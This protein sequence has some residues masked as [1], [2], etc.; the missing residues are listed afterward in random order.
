VKDMAKKIIDL[1]QYKNVK[2]DYQKLLEQNPYTVLSFNDY[3][4]V[5]EFLEKVHRAKLKK[6]QEKKE[7]K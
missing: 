3:F 2:A 6:R 1:D 7:N 5:R 4:K